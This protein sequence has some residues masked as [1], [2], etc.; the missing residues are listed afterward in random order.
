MSTTARQERERE[1]ERE[2]FENPK[3]QLKVSEQKIMLTSIASGPR[4]HG[5]SKR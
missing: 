3:D 5:L 1:R 4:K 2:F